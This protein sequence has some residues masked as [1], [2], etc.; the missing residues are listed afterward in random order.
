RSAIRMR[1]L[2][3]SWAGRHYL[4]W[5]GGVS[6]HSLVRQINPSAAFKRGWAH[7]MS[8]VLETRGY[9]DDQD[10][11]LLNQRRLALAEQACI[12]LEF[13]TGE[14]DSQQ[15]LQRLKPLSDIPCWAEVSLT[16][17]SRRPTDA[18]MALLGADLLEQLSNR[19][20]EQNAAASIKQLHE[21]LLAHGAVALPLVVKRAL[22]QQEWDQALSEV[23]S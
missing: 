16:A 14:I 18:F 22:G 19:Y 5:A 20:L 21:Q 10:R 13:H 7:Y 11:I 2:Y 1:N 23:L 12:D 4:A 15:A 8:R 6:A 9:F 3:S 17:I